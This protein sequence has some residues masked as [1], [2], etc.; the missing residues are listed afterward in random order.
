MRDPDAKSIPTGIIVSS[1][2]TTSAPHLMSGVAK[3]A[4]ER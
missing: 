4:L 2:R 3:V 1:V